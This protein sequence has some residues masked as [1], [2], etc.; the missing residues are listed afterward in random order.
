MNKK[1]NQKQKVPGKLTPAD[2]E[3]LAQIA[4]FKV[5][6]VTQI[7]ALTQRSRQVVRRRLRFFGKENL[8]SARSRAFGAGP[9]ARENVFSA[10]EATLAALGSNKKMPRY[11]VCVEGKAVEPLFIEHELL[12]NWFFIHLHHIQRAEPRFKVQYVIASSNCANPV[13]STGTSSVLR[14]AI[15]ESAD[16][17]HVIVPDTD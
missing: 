4:K 16:E 10:T 2:V 6:T 15:S 11:A 1:M 8:V 14:F 3:I 17:S 9:G 13:K 5:L 7:A 12:V